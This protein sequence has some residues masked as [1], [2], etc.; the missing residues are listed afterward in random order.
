LQLSLNLKGMHYQPSFVSGNQYEDLANHVKASLIQPPDEE[1]IEEELR[2][3]EEIHRLEKETRAREQEL[4]MKRN[5]IYEERMQ[6][7]EN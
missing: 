1:E 6:K 2:N 4:K 5:H 7:I 3:V